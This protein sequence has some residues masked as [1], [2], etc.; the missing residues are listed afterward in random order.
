MSHARCHILRHL[1]TEHLGGLDNNT[2]DKISVTG[3]HIEEDANDD[4]GLTFGALEQDA[5]DVTPVY[6]GAPWRNIIVPIN[7]TLTAFGSHKKKD[8]PMKRRN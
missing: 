5:S 1:E 3:D 4:E 8:G 2:L 6:V 7:D